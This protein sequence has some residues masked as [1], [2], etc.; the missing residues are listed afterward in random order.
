MGDVKRYV[1][2]YIPHDQSVERTLWLDND[3]TMTFSGPVGMRFTKQEAQ[4]VLKRV[5]GDSRGSLRI[6]ELTDEVIR[7]VE[8]MERICEDNPTQFTDRELSLLRMLGH[9]RN[10][11]VWRIVEQVGQ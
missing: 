5:S 9:Q 3:K 8:A 1:I 4:R 7:I 10:A 2:A 11:L 6:V